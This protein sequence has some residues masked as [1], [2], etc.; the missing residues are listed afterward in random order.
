MVIS[1]ENVSFT[2]NGQHILSNIHWQVRSEEHWCLLGLNGSGKTTLLNLICGYL[3]PSKGKISVLGHRYGT[4][5]L[6]ELRKQI[7]W[8]SSSFQE[9]IHGSET[10]EKI[11]LSGKFASIGIYDT[12]SDA[13]M[14]EAKRLMS[15]LGCEHLAGRSYQTLS[16]GEKQRIVIARALMA[17]PKLLILDEPCTGLDLFAREHVLHSIEKIASQPNAPTL[18]YVTHHIEEILPCFTHTFLLKD[19]MSFLQG[20]T[21]QVLTSTTLSAFFDLPVEV[22][23]KHH[24]F[25]VSFDSKGVQQR[26]EE[27]T[28]T[29][30]IFSK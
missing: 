29:S 20:E 13:D 27:W 15:F 22:E 1:V 21:N 11:V 16:Q 18:I 26:F 24:R 8:V 10:A 5:D 28:A 7:G 6:R 30:E 19:G 4:V 17:K 23:K 3:W 14:E 9:K 2:R 12:F 25:W